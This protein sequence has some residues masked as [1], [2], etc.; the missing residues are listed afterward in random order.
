MCGDL[1]GVVGGRGYERGVSPL[2]PP[3]DTWSEAGDNSE[4]LEQ[5]TIQPSSVHH[6]LCKFM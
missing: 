2:T 5:L 1:V 4:A 3:V 6:I